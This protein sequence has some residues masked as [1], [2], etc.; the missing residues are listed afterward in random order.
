MTKAELPRL[1]IGELQK[2]LRNREVSPREVLEALHERIEALDPKI[3]AYLWRDLDAA[4]DAADK[5]DVNL[6]LGGIPLAI[7]DVINVEGQPCTCASKILRGY[8]ALFDA[9]V[10]Q[11]LR[12]AGAIPF[13]RTNMDEFAM[14]TSTENS[15][16]GPTRNPWDIAR[17]PGGSDRRLGGGGGG[18]RSHRR[19]RH[20][21]RRLH[22]PARRAL[23]RGRAQ[24]DLRPRL[25]LTAWSRSPRRSTRS[26]RSRR[27]CAMRRSCSA[28][29]RATIRTI[30]PA[31]TQPVPDY[32]AA[33]ERNLRGVRL[34][35]P[36]EYLIGG[37][38]PGSGSRRC[39]AAV[40][41][42]EDLARR[43]SKFRCR[44]RIMRSPSIT[45]S[46]PPRLRRNLA[47][48]DGVRY[49]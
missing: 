41:Q 42:Y 49:G 16:F 33:L 3:D 17:I 25:A 39:D 43:S 32:A 44:T 13:G 45:S 2:M 36:K 22:P 28:S 29:W 4:I 23:R 15:A 6:S 14:G 30:P 9:T 37:H 48:F 34:G 35:L 47:R 10:I 38:R 5:V 31:S 46:P 24:A 26:G 21:H 7:K 8:R 40:E 27:T 20:G 11:K 12:A 1:T 18:G 19:A